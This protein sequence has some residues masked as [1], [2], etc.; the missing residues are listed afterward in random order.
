MIPPLTAAPGRD[1]N[2]ISCITAR[3]LVRNLVGAMTRAGYVE[4]G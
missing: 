3:R 1:L 4:R 2:G